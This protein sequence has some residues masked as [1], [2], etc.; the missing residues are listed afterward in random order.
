MLM[1][2][3]GLLLAGLFVP[4][5]KVSAGSTPAARGAELFASKGCAHCHGPAGIGGE[6]G[7][8]LQMVRKR[9]TASAMV[10]QISDGGQAM[11]AFRDSLSTEEIDDL[12]AYLRAKRKLVRLPHKPVPPAD[13]S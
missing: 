9:M 5:A 13:P 8:D 1:G 2:G 11:P 10:K 3:A 6:I 12:V 7:P 4:A